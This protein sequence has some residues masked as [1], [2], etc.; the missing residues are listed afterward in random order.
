MLRGRAVAAALCV[1]VPAARADLFGQD[2][3]DQI[4]KIY[5]LL[6]IPPAGMIQSGTKGLKHFRKSDDGPDYVLRHS[7]SVRHRSLNDVLGVETGGPDGRRLNEAGHSVTDYLKLKVRGAMRCVF[8]AGRG[9]G[10]DTF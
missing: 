7:R 3:A 9:F 2:E 4:V 1:L 5:E 8:F 10:M 6:G